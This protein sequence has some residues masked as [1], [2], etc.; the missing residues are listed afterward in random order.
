M[1]PSQVEES[2]INDRVIWACLAI[3]LGFGCIVN[4][5]WFEKGA[6]KH[7]LGKE[8]AERIDVIYFMD[9][10]RLGSGSV[11]IFPCGCGVHEDRIV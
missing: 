9:I 3:V 4:L 2:T 8:F 11:L 1:D 7:D 10:W 5:I 6:I